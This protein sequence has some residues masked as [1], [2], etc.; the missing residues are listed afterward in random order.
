M[1]RMIFKI[2]C[3]SLIFP[4]LIKGQKNP[5]RYQFSKPPVDSSTTG[6]KKPYAENTFIYMQEAAFAYYP[7]LKS[8]DIRFKEKKLKTTMAARPGLFSIFGMKKNRVY[9][10]FINNDKKNP[11]SVLLN[12][13]PTNAQVGVIGH[14]YAHILDY[15]SKRNLQLVGY[16]LK[17][18]FSKKFKKNLENSIDEITIS[19]GLGWQVYDFSSYV[20]NDSSVTSEYKA[21]KKKF[22]YTPSEILKQMVENSEVYKNLAFFLQKSHYISSF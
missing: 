8:V 21:Y 6:L 17:Y 20:F 9:Y 4:A 18:I 19:R 3:L 10:I 22:Y 7:E 2:F 5:V 15:Q 14:E 1:W 13:L 12:E 16:G 11:N